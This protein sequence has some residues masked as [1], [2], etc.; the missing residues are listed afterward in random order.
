MKTLL[1][2]LILL[3]AGIIA[4][5]QIMLKPEPNEIAPI[6]PITSVEIIEVQPTT[7]QLT[8]MSQG[9]LLPTVETDLI[10]EVSGRV[11]EV[12]DN[13]RA[14]NHFKKNDVLIKIDPTDYEAAAATREADLANAE[15][16]LAQ[17]QALA[18]QAEADWLAL[19]TGEA[20][21]LTLRKP[22]LKQAM[23]MVK[24]AQAALNKARRDIERTQIIA[25]YNGIVLNKNVDL[26]QF[27][28]TNPS[29][30]LARIYA[31]QSAEVRLPITEQEASFLDRDS[32]EPSS[33]TL[34]QKN[35]DVDVNWIAPLVRIEDNINPSSRL[36]YAVARIQSPFN[37]TVNDHILRR[38]TFLSAE[39]EG[40]SIQNVYSLPRYAL[41]GSDTVYVLTSENTL[42][43]RTIGIVKSDAKQVI[44]DSGLEP[45]DRVATSPIAYYIE[46]MPVE[47]IDQENT[48]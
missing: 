15:L 44:I 37:T 10:S 47:I 29:N 35:N 23:A 19:G 14:G 13:F 45:G 26:G 42:Q 34:T 33:V 32:E 48:Q 9:T 40:R 16:K 41:R 5:F 18:Q 4:A 8:I 12:A 6:R 3:C 43:T 22:Q 20:S 36:L 39:I 27:V 38:G 21:D 2:I 24:S 17:E 25:P 30:P 11:I 31:T 1:P 7:V 28:I 46:G